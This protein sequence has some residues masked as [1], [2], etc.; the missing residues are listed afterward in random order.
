MKFRFLY[1][2]LLSVVAVSCSINEIAAPDHVETA[3][4]ADRI[5]YATIA[6]QASEVDTKVFANEEFRIR[7]NAGDHITIFEKNT[8][9]AEFS[10]SDDIEDGSNHA[11]FKPATNEYYTGNPLDMYYAIYPYQEGTSI[12]DD[13][14][15]SFVLPEKQTYLNKSFGKGANT[16]VSMTEN[17]NLM[18]KNAGGYLCFKLYGDNV[19][20]S[21][22]IL[23]GNGGEA[24]AGDCIITVSDDGIPTVAMGDEGSTTNVVRLNCDE[25]VKIGSSSEDYTEFW[26]VLPPVEFEASKGGFTLIVATPDGGVFTQDAP[27]D[28]TISRNVIQKM[29][30]LKVKPTA[31]TLS[32]N[33]VSSKAGGYGVSVKKAD[34]SIYY[35]YASFDESSRTYTITLPTVTDFSELV[36]DYTFTGDKLMVGDQVI[37]SGETP[38]DASS[39]VTIKVCKGYAEKDYTLVARNTGLPVVRITTTPFTRADV[40]ADRVYTQSTGWGER[41]KIDE[42]KWRPSV[43]SVDSSAF[44]TF[45]TVDGKK[46]TE[47]KTQIKGR[48]N[49]TWKYNKRPYALKLLEKNKVFDMPKHKRWILLANWKDRTLLRNDA[50]FWLSKQTVMPDPDDDTKT[51]GLPYTVR[52][53]FVE[54]EFNGEHRGNYYLCEQIKIDKNRVN[55]SKWDPAVDTVETTGGF[56]M[57][58]DNNYDE[59]NKFKSSQYKLKYM[60]KDP[61][62][63]LTTDAINYMKNFINALEVKIKNASN[64]QYRDDFDIDA[65][66]WFMFVNELTGNG[67]FYNENYSDEYKGPHSTYL[68]KDKGGK[69]TM[70][71]V[72]DFD[73]LTF[74]PS[75]SSKWA[76]ANQTGYYYKSMI[77]DPVFKARLIQLWGLYQSQLSGFND[78]IDSMVRQISISEE[79]NTTM[80]GYSNTSQDQGQNGDNGET[81]QN[82][83]SMMKEAFAN[84]KSW[85]DQQFKKTNFSF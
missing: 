15:I 69:L 64:G 83:V 30:P 44:V 31:Q 63:D 40:E 46:I 4:P 28:L 37:V 17:R 23:K 35:N 78:Y 47:Y 42:R 74:M 20:V 36:F 76:G 67:D 39:P 22:V 48:G 32:L 16:M 41:T 72:W 3:S 73:Y 85:M 8:Y 56:M 14:V 33:S 24:L 65:A 66:I 21:S 43:S 2:G 57:E 59:A 75:R 79:F 60:F 80:W 26:F 77:N 58:I 27:M 7:W 51:L 84:K 71:P 55:I 52:G 81:F 70:G 1:I 5:F 25:P 13:G 45:E 38:I 18:F 12:S 50:A 61:D 19:S 82:A 6:D 10:V 54:L 68:Y 11:S 62:D 29:A 53:Q 34:G 49:A 9:G